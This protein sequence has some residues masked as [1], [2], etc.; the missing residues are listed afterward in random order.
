MKK[1]S[2][3]VLVLFALLA[4]GIY[5][6]RLDDDPSDRVETA[7]QAES[8]IRKGQLAPDF[9]LSDRAGNPVRLSDFRGRTVFVN[10]WATWC[11]PCKAEMPHMQ[12]V[13]EE[14][15]EQDVVILS[16]NLTTTEKKAAA[17]DHFVSEYGLTFP[18]V[19]DAD[20]T[21]KQLYQ[22]TAYPT[23][24]VLDKQGIIRN[25]FTGAINDETMKQVIRNMDSF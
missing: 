18:V 7:R 23:T 9:Q 15:K 16:V 11:P 21:V 20:G 6:S 22:V 10:F 4:Y 3:G 1:T 14:Y 25:K 8:G 2:I 17:V 19:L 5:Q 13:Y 12:R 24:Y